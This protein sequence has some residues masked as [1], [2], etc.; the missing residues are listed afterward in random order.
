MSIFRTLELECPACK[1]ALRFDLV[2]SV[3]ADRRPDLRDAILDGSFQRESCPHCGSRFRVEPEFTYMDIGRGQYIGV[4]PLGKRRDWEAWA[5]KTRSVFD[6]AMGRHASPEARAIGDGLEV[7]TVFGWRALVEKILARQMGIDDRTLEIAKL[8]VM[9]SQERAPVPGRI[10]LRLVGER[11]GD[12]VLAWAGARSEDEAPPMMRVPRQLIAD[13]EADPAS[14]Q[15][16]RDGVA[17]HDVVDFQRDM[18]AA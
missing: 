5:A 11:D 4:W 9:R 8:A 14:W 18:L 13:I 15:K 1:S 7:R 16:A 10:T 6:D 2:M 17:S 3:S 12:L